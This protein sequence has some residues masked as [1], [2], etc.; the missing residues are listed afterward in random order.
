MQN[1]LD[2]ETERH[3]HMLARAMF[4]EQVLKKNLDE[5]ADAGVRTKMRDFLH[6]TYM[7]AR[8]VEGM[9]A[10]A[11]AMSET[12]LMNLATELPV[13]PEMLETGEFSPARL[14]EAARTQ[15]EERPHVSFLVKDSVDNVPVGWVPYDALATEPLYR[16]RTGGGYRF[17]IEGMKITD[18]GSGFDSQLTALYLS[19]K[20]GKRHL[21]GKFAEGAKMSELHVLRGRASMKMRSTY[22]TRN[23]GEVLKT[24][25]WQAKPVLHDGKLVS[26]GVEVQGEEDAQTGSSVEVL[27]K[28][29][30]ESFMNEFL[31]NVDPRLRGLGKN[32]AEFGPS[33]FHYPMPTT[34]SNLVG[35]NIRGDGSEQFVQGIRV[36]LGEKAFGYEKPWFSYNFLD[37]SIIAGR[38]RSEVNAKIRERVHEFWYQNDD[39]TSLARLVEIAVRDAHRHGQKRAVPEIEALD[40]ILH[41]SRDAITVR[42]DSGP[43]TFDVE[44]IGRIVDELLVKQLQLVKNQATLIVTNSQKND[45]QFRETLLFAQYR[46]YE[47]REVMAEIGYGALKSFCVRLSP[48]YKVTTVYD[49]EAERQNNESEQKREIVEGERERMMREA[50]NATVLS[51]TNLLGAAGMGTKTFTL[52]FEASHDEDVSRAYRRHSPPS[53]IVLSHRSGEHYDVVVDPNDIKD[54]R[55]VGSRALQRQLEAYILSAFAGGDGESDQTEILKQSQRLLDRLIKRLIPANSPVLT[56]IPD[57]IG[58]VRDASVIE[59][60]K[61]L[62]FDDRVARHERK[63]HAAD[64]HEEAVSASLTF[65]DARQ[66]LEREDLTEPPTRFILQ[67]RVF[68]ENGEVGFFDEKARPMRQRL[69]D[70]PKVAEWRSLPAYALDDNRYFVLAPMLGGAVLAKG[71]GKKREY[72]LSD[73][74]RFLHIANPLVHYESYGESFDDRISVH[75]D[76]F[77]LNFAKNNKDGMRGLTPKERVAR[78]LAEYTHY[79]AGVQSIGRLFEGRARTSIPIEYGKEEWDNPVR[80]FQDVVQNH[81]D[82]CKNGERPLLSY[83]IERDDG[84]RIWKKAD[85]VLPTDTL[86]GVAVEDKGDGYLPSE[87]ATLGASSKKSPLFA[88]KYGEGQKMIA[89]AALR[90]GLELTYESGLKDAEGNAWRARAISESRTVVLD[91]EEVP[92]QLVAFDV[93]TREGLEGSRTILRLPDAPSSEQFA[94]WSQWVSTINPWEKDA[95]GFGGLE[96]YIRQLRDPAKE[97]TESVGSVTILRDEPGA[98]YENGLRINPSAERGRNLAYGYDVPEV[99]NTRERNSYNSDRFLNYARHALARAKDPTILGDVLMKAMKSQLGN[100]IDLTRIMYV[101]VHTH[102]AWES[103]AHE[104]WRDSAVYSSQA[105]AKDIEGDRHIHDAEDRRNDRARRE[106]ASRLKADLA[107]FD[108]KTLVDVPKDAYDGFAYLLPTLEEVS[109]RIRREAMEPPAHIKN[110]LADVVA[111]CTKTFAEMHGMAERELTKEQLQY[112]A[113]SGSMLQFAEELWGD[114]AVIT[115]RNRD[116]VLLAPFDSPF[117]GRA[118]NGIAFNEGLLLPGQKS[119]LAETALHEVAHAVSGYNDYTEEFVGV[120]NELAHHLA[121][122]KVQT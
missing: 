49:I 57:D 76:G 120:L 59:R 82:A 60:A 20:A 98:V 26:Q 86:V 35:V 38:D 104:L 77:V 2:A 36:E 1:H 37:S 108:K 75:P 34:A 8:H 22:Q 16:N 111:N 51:V 33:A 55:L 83:E 97:R 114:A 24:R 101:D 106:K 93:E 66:L 58:Y 74:E 50:F 103:A 25:S 73:G 109:N 115:R 3:F 96:R 63:K 118:N 52:A 61:T 70:L 91:G 13:R 17:A 110:I 89:A 121:S 79:P 15:P 48:E 84:Y 116:G 81:V 10:H 95:R 56:A 12:D 78:S 6:R 54:P 7:F 80:V 5:K 65:D 90:N 28:G 71:E 113:I 62:M 43:R 102:P 30:N 117:H 122:K 107:H 39:P 119:E 41:A 44:R 105:I 4:D 53:P 99:V 68:V 45:Q 85:E 11:R 87:I 27:L 40:G 21:R 72:S 23:G 32:I 19:S 94:L 46:G 100:D 88:G 31:E 9:S 112:Y 42:D 14:L 64:L 47:I 18:H 69:S 67:R 92:K 29:A